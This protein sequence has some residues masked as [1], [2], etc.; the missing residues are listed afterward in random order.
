MDGHVWRAVTKAATDIARLIVPVACPGCGL[1]DVRWCDDCAAVWWEPPLRCE[2][3]A[4]RLMRSSGTLPAWSITPLEATAHRMVGAW[5]DGGRRDLDAFFAT[6]MARTASHVA[7][8]LPVRLTVVPAPARKASNRRRGVNLPVILAHATAAALRESGTDARVVEALNLGRGESRGQSART[9]WTKTGVSLEQVR[10]LPPG[11]GVLLVD[12]VLTTGATIAACA[13]RL[14]QPLAPVM[15]ALV[16]ASAREPTA[17]IAATSSH[18]V[19]SV[20]RPD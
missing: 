5:K 12:D 11:A 10:P 4:P 15:G 6:A 8:S 19:G 1:F 2:S 9:R 16:L 3:A 17:G 20:T 13:S 18:R 7:G 14:S